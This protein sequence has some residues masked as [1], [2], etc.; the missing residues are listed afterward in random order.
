MTDDKYV[1]FLLAHT[2]LRQS[3]VAKKLLIITFRPLYSSHHT[4]DDDC[5]KVM[6]TLKVS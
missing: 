4:T 3:T 2:T 5:C 1:R 6:E